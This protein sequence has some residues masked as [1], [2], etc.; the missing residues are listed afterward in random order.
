[1]FE[2]EIEL[3]DLVEVI[4]YGEVMKSMKWTHRLAKRLDDSRSEFYQASR[5][6]LRPEITFAIHDFEYSNEEYVR[7]DGN[8]YSIVRAAKRGDLRELVCTA[9]VGASN[10]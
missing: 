1:M 9:K 2:E 8:E 5:A 4:E 10:G 7:H 6:G 3:G